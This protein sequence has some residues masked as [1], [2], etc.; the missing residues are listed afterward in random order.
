M[1]FIVVYYMPLQWSAGMRL[2]QNNIGAQKDLSKCA[3]SYIWPTS[4]ATP[5]LEYPVHK[6]KF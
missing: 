6:Q 3:L 5:S 2:T 4:N 1:L